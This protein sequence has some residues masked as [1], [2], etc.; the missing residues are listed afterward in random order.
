MGLAGSDLHPFVAS[1]GWTL[2]NFVWQGATIGLFFAVVMKV[3]G[4]SS[5][6]SRHAVAL[7]FLVLIGLVPLLTFSL[8]FAS[9]ARVDATGGI[10]A[11]WWSDVAGSLAWL[12][13]WAVV[14]WMLG[15]VGLSGRLARDWMALRRL[16]RDGTRP[17]SPEM[18]ALARRVMETYAVRMPV[19][20]LESALVGVPVAVGWL[21][22]I[23]LVPPAALM[24]LTAVQLELILAH[25]AAHIRRYDHLVNMYQVI[26][27]TLLFYHPA[28]R[29]ISNRVRVERENCCDDLVA[30]R[31]G[32]SVAYARALAELEGLRCNSPPLALA[33]TDGQLLKR[34]RRLVTRQDSQRGAMAWAIGL[35][36]VLT[37]IAVLGGAG[38]AVL[39]KTA[40]DTQP[41]ADAVLGSGRERVA[42]IAEQPMSSAA[43]LPIVLAQR[44]SEPAEQT[45]AMPLTTAK[46][47]T[48]AVTAEVA[49]REASQA[50]ISPAPRPP[51]A[52]AG[53]VQEIL[54]IPPSSLPKRRLETLVR[55]APAAQPAPPRDE[56][57]KG[58]GQ[59]LDEVWSTWPQAPKTAAVPA[60]EVYTGGELVKGQPPRFPRE[61][62]MLPDGGWVVARFTVSRR[63]RV[64]GLTII[65]SRPQGIFDRAVTKA[66][67]KWR[68][69]P[70]K[71]EG[72]A[73]AR[74]ITQAF[75]FEPDPDLR[76]KGAAQQ[77]CKVVTGSRLCRTQFAEPWERGVEV[78][79]QARN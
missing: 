75:E 58:V 46:A 79:Y 36:L 15:V 17:L 1:L 3:M 59:L 22:P 13:P 14:G 57:D 67:S 35:L 62:K 54:E 48:P 72:M 68:F 65:E 69:K 18:D 42:L 45:V 6:A 70:Y 39:S 38:L 43:F 28:V 78:I 40:R 50:T 37:N 44:S 64:E 55:P 10:T 26:I 5:A 77:P 60:A 12:L 53:P 25:E 66:V 63:G 9:A 19:K 51:L 33:A 27:E 49:E 21:K 56:L 32:D 76:V 41:P 8:L 23:I 7:A 16:V 30:V 20:V 34:I 74:T 24:G 61:A 31:C 2:I 73:V 11:F 29:W 52:Q 47:A 71:L 4:R